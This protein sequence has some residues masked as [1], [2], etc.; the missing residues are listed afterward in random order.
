[1][2]STASHFSFCEHTSAASRDRFVSVEGTL[3]DGAPP[4]AIARAHDSGRWASRT[5]HLEFAHPW[6]V[7][8]TKI[9]PVEGFH[10]NRHSAAAVHPS[11]VCPV[12][13]RSLAAYCPTACGV[14]SL[15]ALPLWHLWA[16]GVY[17][18]RGA[19]TGAVA[20]EAPATTV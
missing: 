8:T 10:L 12:D 3:G 1:M 11:S 14:L 20:V 2:E 19:T 7:L 15:R 18:W 16:L 5:V 9:P 6:L 13:A 17:R 4:L